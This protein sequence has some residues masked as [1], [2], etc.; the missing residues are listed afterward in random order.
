MSADLDF[1]CQHFCANV[2]YGEMDRACS[3]N[4]REEELIGYWWERQKE[5]KHSE[6]QDVDGR[7]ILR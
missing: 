2:T 6:N 4:G 7:T 1:A 3:I 5:R